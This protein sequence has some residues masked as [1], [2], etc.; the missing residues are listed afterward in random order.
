MNPI[1]QAREALE[2]ILDHYVNLANSGDAGFWNPEEEPEVIGVRAA[3]AA[4][5]ASQAHADLLK[6]EALADA[7]AKAAATAHVESLYGGSKDYTREC[8]G[9]S[10]KARSDLMQALSAAPAAPTQGAQ[11]MPIETAPKDG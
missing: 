2:A 9:K 1:E 6:L 8:V 4:L 5:S 3:L 7:Y 10:N 11:W